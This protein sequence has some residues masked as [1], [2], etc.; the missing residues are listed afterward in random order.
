MQDTIVKAIQ[1]EHQFEPGTNLKAWLFTILRNRM[2]SILNMK[3]F[4]NVSLDAELEGGKNTTLLGW[5][6]SGD[7]RT[8]FTKI[9]LAETLRE[10]ARFPDQANVLLDMLDGM[11]YE[12]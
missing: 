7:T 10:I 5:L 8:G 11:S 1:A 9:D 4:G 3:E 2:Y 6:E 12:K